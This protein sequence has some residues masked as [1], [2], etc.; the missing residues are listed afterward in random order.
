MDH[1]ILDVISSPA[2]LKLLTN[3]ELSILAREIREEIVSVTSETGGH[4]GSSLGAVEIILAVHSMLDCPRDRFIF[5]VG[6]QAYAHK[7]V[8]GRLE[9]FKSLRTYGGLSGF[10]KP[11]ES[12]YDV[13][14]S[15]HASDS[16]SVALGLAKARDLSG[17]DN[18]VVALIGD[19][20]LS[21]GMAFEALNHIGQ[22]QTPMVVVLND[23][24]MSISRNVGAL[25]KHLG[26]MRASSQYRQT[27]DSVQERLESSGPF[28]EA[29]A[30][31]GRNMKESMKQ[32]V[33]PRTMIFE[34][35]GIL[36]TAPIDGHDIGALKETLAMVL[37]TDAP[38]LMHVVTKKGAGYGPAVR[39]PEKFHGIAPYDV[40][41]GAVKK[42]PSAAPSYTS[43][44]GAALAA[45]ARKDERVVAITAAMKD[46]TGL[47]GFAEEFPSR[48]VDSGIA[49][50][51]AVGLA[52]GLAIGGKKPV[53]AIYSTFL[54]RAVDQLVINNALPNLDVVFAIDRAGVVGEDGP[55]H[56]G[57]FDLAY[58]R[59]VPHMRVLAPSNEAELVHA[60]HTALALGGPFAIRYPRG[61]A[62]GVPLPE[63][64]Q[65]L[66]V[67]KS[68]VVREGAD[69]AILAFGRM[70][71]RALGAAELLAA[72]GIDA[73]V[74]DM[75]WAKPLDADAIARAA[76]T[77]LVVTVEG[78]IVSGGAGEGVLGEL[79][80]QGLAVPALTLG[81]PD[82]F[83]PQG[84]AD[85]L[86]RDLGLDPE[87]IAASIEEHM[88]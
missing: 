13:H 9:E 30:N 64:P 19:A 44:F 84:K 43:V 32:F 29:L 7:L 68:Q 31:F 56:H 38:V 10:P 70:V 24:E 72:R 60:L 45:E 47:A 81:I 40:A 71:G 34:Q 2:D 61:A 87:G 28:G 69:V 65:V 36:C 3:E 8:T 18:K 12:P 83:V 63:E 37:E 33:L 5:D 58:T 62:E 55:T 53:V 17:G 4:V 1:R 79:A 27:R 51:H 50:E 86:L 52:S 66:E 76:Q 59:M 26:Y 23:N 88:K 14:P 11:G 15:G 77:R 39:N 21:G 75:R 67:G 82:M 46:G 80:R 20:A 16:L 57:M 73:R 49:E 48:F 42:K 35:L 54:Q 22:A 6:H 85:L 78:G 25:M 41:T 74:V